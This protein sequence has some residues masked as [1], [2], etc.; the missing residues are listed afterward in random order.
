LEIISVPK[1]KY[2][3][4]DVTETASLYVFRSRRDE[5]HMYLMQKEVLQQG[6][7]KL[8]ELRAPIQ[9]VRHKS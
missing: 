6:R 9:H 5:N 8:Y 3:P 2:L 7:D 1:V 4:R